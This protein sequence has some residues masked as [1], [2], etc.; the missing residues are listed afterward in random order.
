MRMLF[1]HL[2]ISFTWKECTEFIGSPILA[3]NTWSL[4]DVRSSE[5][6]CKPITSGRFINAVSNCAQFIRYIFTISDL[7]WFTKVHWHVQLVKMCSL[8]HF[9]SGRNNKHVH[10]AQS[11]R[12]TDTPWCAHT[13]AHYNCDTSSDWLVWCT[14][15]ARSCTVS[16]YDCVQKKNFKHEL[17]LVHR[18][19]GS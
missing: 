3:I 16:K 7:Y 12:H 8:E 10:R 11:Y 18:C 14:T 6:D 1:F 2:V 15:R 13:H 5:L 4:F 19:P 9:S 17:R